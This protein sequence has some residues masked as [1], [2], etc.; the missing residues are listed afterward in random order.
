MRSVSGSTSPVIL[1]VDGQAREILEK[2]QGGIFVE[3]ENATALVAAIAKLY[4]DPGSVMF[5]V[6]TADAISPSTSPGSV[7]RT[8]TP[9]F[10]KSLS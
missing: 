1:G 8:F 4:G 2:A 9:V 5:L 6:V 10:S 7:W 3:P